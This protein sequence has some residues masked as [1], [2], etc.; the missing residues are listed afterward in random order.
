MIS[1]TH[2][3]SF[4]ILYLFIQLLSSFHFIDLK[5]SLVLCSFNPSRDWGDQGAAAEERYR[6]GDGGRHSSHPCA[7]FQGPQPH[8]RQTG[9]DA[10]STHRI[11]CWSDHELLT[12][13]SPAYNCHFKSEASSYFLQNT[14][15]LFGF[16]SVYF[17]SA[18]TQVATPDWVSQDDPTDGLECWEPPSSTSS[19]TQCSRSPRRL[20]LNCY[21]IV[22]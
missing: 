10:N 3:E 16:C 8:L 9:Y 17:F 1:F 20:I 22:F 4:I 15:C 19:E 11:V 13:W 12:R 6:C 14:F 7:A 2:H 21:Q 18:L 5:V